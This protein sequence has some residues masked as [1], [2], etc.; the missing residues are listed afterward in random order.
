[1]KH[2]VDE[3]WMSWIFRETDPKTSRELAAHRKSCPE[4]DRRVQRWEGTLG[5][6]NLKA[7]PSLRRSR[8]I[9]DTAWTIPRWVPAAAVLMLG[10]V[11]GW[12][13]RSASSAMDQAKLRTELQSQWNDQFESLRSEMRAEIT[14]EIESARAANSA[15]FAAALTEVQRRYNQQLVALREDLEVMA[16]NTQATLEV[17]EQQLVQLALNPSPSSSPSLESRQ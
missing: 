10:L 9:R 6:L 12:L 7:D 8:S 3:V 2:P 13:S 11:A 4:C 17:A 14:T 15:A 16:I 1:M 5:Q